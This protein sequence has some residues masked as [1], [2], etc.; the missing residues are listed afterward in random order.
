MKSSVHINEQNIDKIVE[1]EKEKISS[2]QN[3]DD[4]EEEIFYFNEKND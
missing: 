4:M 3:L 2:L 1:T